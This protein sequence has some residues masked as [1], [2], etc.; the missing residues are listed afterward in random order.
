MNQQ[1]VWVGA[2]ALVAAACAANPA[3]SGGGGSA[4]SA[5]SGGAAGSAA[6]GGSGGF[7][8]LGGSGGF[9]ALGGGGGLGG[10][11]AIDGGYAAA[12]GGNPNLVGPDGG[13]CVEGVVCVPANPDGEGCG[14]LTLDTEV[15]TVKVPGNLLLVFDRSGSMDQE[16]NGMPRWQATGTAMLNALTPI[17]SDLTIGMVS[18]PSPGGPA[19]TCAPLDFVCLL[20]IGST[21]NCE[22]N[23]IDAA[24]QI[25]FKPG[26]MALQEL[27]GP[28]PKYQPVAGGRTP[29]SEG[30]ARANEALNAT[31][32]TGAI[33]VVLITD[34][35]PNCSWDQVSTVAIIAGWLA[36]GIQTYVV[37]LPGLNSGGMT[38]LNALA[39]AGGTGTFLTPVDSAQLTAQMA[40]IVSSTIS[41]GFN[42]C[43]ITINPP[44]AVPDELQLVVTENG[45]EY[46]VAHDLGNGAGWTITPDGSLVELTG[47]LC[48]DAKGGRFS[49][50]EFKF[51][52]IDIPQLPPPPPPE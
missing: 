47:A 5:G 12:D 33:A 17:A 23:P 43:S 1:W 26:P 41:V 6:V 29:T 36:R 3:D 20:G 11:A 49:K 10:F 37:G 28:P 50:L 8:A 16:W 2:A 7:G 14:S 13:P 9:G 52:C 44:T 19:V 30:I 4:G 22:V 21:G 32:L 38:N 24:D 15:E 46:G 45:T 48:D 40:S 39:T 34:G 25:T 27:M 18:F 42:S 31:Q 51:G 35:A